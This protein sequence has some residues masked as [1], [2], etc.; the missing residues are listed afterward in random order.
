MMSLKSFAIDREESRKIFLLFGFLFCVVSAS[1]IGRTV[2]D[3]LFLSKFDSSAL[4]YM[5][6][7]QAATLFTIGFIYQKVCGMLRTNQL[8]IGVILIAS[9][10]TVLSRLLVGFGVEWIIPVI[11]IGYD[12][13][14]FLM[15]VCFWQFATAVMDQRKAKKTIN[16]VGSG[17]IVGAIASGFGLKLLVGPLGTVNLI[18][19][20]S[21]LQLLCLLFVYLINRSIP[22]TNE[23]AAPMKLVPKRAVKP[24]THKAPGKNGLFKNVP[25]LKFVGITAGLLVIALT[26]IDY[27]FKVIL[28]ETLQN[29]ALAGFMGSFYG[30]AGIL[31]LLVQTFVSGK[32]ITRFGVMIAILVF[33]GVLF[34]GSVAVIIVPVLAIATAVKGTDK[35]LGDTINSSVNQLIMFPIAPEWRGRAKG[36]L[37]GIVRNGSK[38]VAAITLILATQWLTLHELSYLISCLIACA[39]LAALKIKKHYLQMLLATLKTREMNPEVET[40]DMMDPASVAILV[41]ALQSPQKQQ[42]LYALGTLQ[43]LKGFNMGPYL[44]ELLN[45]AVFEVRLETLKYIQDHIPPEAEKEL[46]SLLDCSDAKIRAAAVLTLSAYASEGNLEQIAAF[47]EDAEIEVKSAS[48]A[49]LIKYYGIEGMFRAVGVLKQLIDS[50]ETEERMAMAAIFG[51]IGI[52]EFYKPLIPL[53]QD[54]K[55]PVRVLAI[56]SAAILCVPELVA[57]LVPQLLQSTTRLKTIEALAAYN[58]QEIVILLEPYLHEPEINYYLPS[59]FERI[60]T[61]QAFEILLRHYEK[62]NSDLRN[63]VVVSFTKMIREN[64]RMDAGIGERLILQ[65]IAFY[66]EYSKHM[67]DIKNNRDFAVIMDALKYN[68]EQLIQRI[69]HLLGL[70]FDAKTIQAVYTNWSKG[71]ARQHANAVEIIDQLVKGTLRTEIIKLMSHS[72]LHN[73]NLQSPKVIE[74]AVIWFYQQG[75]AYLNH[76]ILQ[77]VRISKAS[78]W[79]AITKLIYADKTAAEQDQMIDQLNQCA[80]LQKVTLFQGLAG[81]DLLNLIDYLHVET[82]DQQHV[83]VK[84]M[85][86]GDSL[87]IIKSGHAGVYRDGVKIADLGPNDS[88]G[89]M[90]LLTGSV[91]TATLIAQENMQIYRLDSDSFYEILFD[92]TEIALG[93]MKLLSR[94]LRSA[95]DKVVSQM[96]ALN[97]AA[98]TV[99]PIAVSEAAAEIGLAPLDIPANRTAVELPRNEIL[100]R[101]V[102]VLQKISLFAHLPQE[103]FVQLA[104]LV[105]E[106]FYAPGEAICRQGEDGDAMYA[107]LDGEVRIHKGAE[108]L[109]ILGEGECFGEMAI[110][111]G[112]ARS[113][114]CTSKANSTLLVLTRDQVFNFCFQHIHVLKSMMRVLAERLQ[115]TQ[116]RG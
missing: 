56:E 109:A 76:L 116:F 90:A 64:C 72:H 71:D 106:S 49:G 83:I 48:I 43:G 17:G 45:H 58:D 112:E 15:I 85:E 75:E 51:Q 28:K 104:Q 54:P 93:M 89:E 39:I 33:P 98:T 8:V 105:E 77:G 6:L 52:R 25:H 34:L 60:G 97:D 5:Y 87:F 69:F 86:N 24:N 44:H 4:S 40:L 29:D 74:S 31:A 100:L 30:F 12:V 101:R 22:K 50:K 11:Y 55:I 61:Q 92:R 66:W 94:R 9:A 67:T 38:G 91:R 73:E 14:N 7:P 99:E 113:A 20:Y 32:V 62:Y 88:F 63:K 111:D 115:E 108:N 81:K 59:V 80:V 1:T 13:L 103:D 110:I 36:F 47:L 16:L 68:G 96:S 35:V 21:V 2:A 19:I 27:Q 95:N 41:D 82:F 37:D 107:I 26:L 114:D 70:I 65:E 42:A 10:L 78:E 3:T 18:V 53:L 84:E 23:D 46:I 57:Y 79:P 102:L